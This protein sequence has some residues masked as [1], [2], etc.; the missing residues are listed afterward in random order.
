VPADSTLVDKSIDCTS[1]PDSVTGVNTKTERLSEWDTRRFTSLLL[2]PSTLQPTVPPTLA[3][4]EFGIG[5]GGAG[6]T[7]TIPFIK[8]KPE[9]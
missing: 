1:V 2:K 7:R 6:F 8:V 4:K 3:W 5:G 9:S